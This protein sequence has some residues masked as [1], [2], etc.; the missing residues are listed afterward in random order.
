M[1]SVVVY[2]TAA[3]A[4]GAVVVVAYFYIFHHP[5]SRRS[6]AVADGAVM[7]A[8]AAPDASEAPEVDASQPSTTLQIRLHDGRRVRAQLNMHHTVRHIQ[9][10]IARYAG[11]HKKVS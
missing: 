5:H 1:P 2:A 3:A 11:V 9:A 8:T 7:D 6:S 4:C 10:I